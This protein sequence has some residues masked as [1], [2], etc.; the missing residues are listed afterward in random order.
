VTVLPLAGDAVQLTVA[1]VEPGVA[2][3][4][5][6]APGTLGVV[7]EFEDAEEAPVPAAFAA[8]TVKV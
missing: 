2:M 6:G 4:T 5:V 7:A 1:L 3:T 8:E